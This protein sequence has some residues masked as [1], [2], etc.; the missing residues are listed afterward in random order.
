[1]SLK[2]GP[3]YK[4]SDLARKTIYELHILMYLGIDYNVIREKNL[5]L[6]LLNY[7][8]NREVYPIEETMLDDASV[9]FKD[10][11]EFRRFAF[12]ILLVWLFECLTLLV[13]S[14]L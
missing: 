8:I 5:E 14:L 6:T 1:M 3:C 4:L 10:R 7:K 13:I 9:V 2:A 11:Q 12:E